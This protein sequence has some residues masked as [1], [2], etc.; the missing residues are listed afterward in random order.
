MQY[1]KTDEIMNLENEITV[2]NTQFDSLQ[3]NWSS[4]ELGEAISLQNELQSKIITKSKQISD[5]YEANST[6]VEIQESFYEWGK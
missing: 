4:Y 3:L 2:L 5:W 6:P 1:V